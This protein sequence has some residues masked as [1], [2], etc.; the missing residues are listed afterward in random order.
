MVT[1]VKGGHLLDLE[2][3]FAPGDLLIDGDVIKRV[4]GDIVQAGAEVID[5]RG[6]VVMPGLINAHTHSNQSIEKGLCDKLPLDAWM[7]LASYGGAGARLEPRD[8]YISAMVGAIE[9]L[10]TGTTS[11][12]DCIRTDFAWFDEGLDAVMQAYA[13]IGMRANVAA[14]YSDLGF[15][16]S[17]PL[18]LIEAP[19]ELLIQER[20]AD[21]GDL[22]T[23]LEGYLDR[24]E[25]RDPLLTPMLGPSAVPRCSVEMF[26]ASLQLARRK[27]ARLQTHL[28]SGKSQ[29]QVG[30]DRYEGS[31][32]QYLRG[33]G[34]LESWAS[35]AHGIWISDEE[36][37]ILAGTDTTIVHNP[38]SNLKLGAGIAPVPALIRA[39]VNVAIGSD[40]AS[41][42]DSQNMFEA[43]KSAALLHRI[44][45]PPDAWPSAQDALRMCWH[46]GAGALGQ[47][48]G[49]LAVGCK[50]DLV[51]MK[52][53]TLFFAPKDQM[54]NQ[55]V[56]AE[57][58][59]SV[60][61]VLVG[62]K[63][64]VR[65]GRIAT[66]D[67]NSLLGEAQELATR[68]WAGLPDRLQRFEKIRPVLEDLERSV[69]QIPLAF[70]RSCG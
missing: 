62:G 17:V 47:P 60:D 57:V 59:R 11:V 30:N 35:F 69:G 46:G 18:S 12:L 70:A 7:V 53:D 24:W 38:V 2:L 21:V 8:L 68:I 31:T 25:G 42:G 65:A 13:D 19:E 49:S 44:A 32:V 14:Q 5:A 39:G 45:N 28:L 52:T 9:M 27:G 48:V 33:L 20:R 36:I 4:G 16:S 51:L 55:L 1:I 3:D 6:M 10:S 67:T 15:F 41:S 64:V 63:V 22:L 58:G 54:M 50:A 37:G 56:Y 43:T 40:G 66:V 23:K 29:V 26:E 34:A 61:T